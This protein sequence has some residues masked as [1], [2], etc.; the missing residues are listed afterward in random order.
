MRQ[1]V[2]PGIGGAL[3]VLLALLPELQLDV[4]GVLPG[5]TW[6]AGTLQLLALCLLVG[7]LAITYD[8]LF[9][10]TGLL[11][12][13]HA[14]YFAVGVYTFAIA[15][16]RWHLGLLPAALLTLAIGTVAAAVVGAISLRVDGISFAMV[17]LAFAQA[18]SLLVYRNFSGY[19]GG[20]E[21]LGLDAARLPGSLVGVDNTQNLYWVCLAICVAVYVLVAWLAGSRAGHTM[22]AVREN[23]LRVRVMGIR[24]YAVR[25]VAFVTAGALA[26]LIGVGYV[27]LQGGANPQVTT[28]TFTLGLLVMVVLGG[29]GSRWGALVGG[30]VYT[31]LDQRLTVL[32]SSSTV[33]GL[34]GALRVPLSQPLFI[35]GVL[36]ILVVLFLP[37]GLAGAVLRLRRSATPR[38]PSAPDIMESAA[39]AA[40]EEVPQ[41]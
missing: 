36:F 11:S 27:L 13:G 2:R 5:P 40:A 33:G 28:P 1:L 35:L 18:G 6:T 39:P 41:R 25:L 7:A 24:P 17:T 21:G 19:T 38:Q 15:L 22:A 32:A 16:Q 4:P 9:G 37:G 12:F 26:T 10:L 34:P 8:L 31:L 3:V 14:L 29:V 23:E 30:V 20:E